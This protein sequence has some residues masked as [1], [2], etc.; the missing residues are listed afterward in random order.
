MDETSGPIMVS[1]LPPRR[2]PLLMISSEEVF[3]KVA[4]LC[5]S[6]QVASKV[7]ISL[8]LVLIPSLTMEQLLWH[9]K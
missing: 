3:C 8:Y 7:V 5:W 1:Y 2:D 6:L 4:G 9:Q